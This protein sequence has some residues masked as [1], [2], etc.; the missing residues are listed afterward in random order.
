MVL[1]YDL[2]ITSRIVTRDVSA[3]RDMLIRSRVWPEA[4]AVI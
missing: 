1:C 4:W 2:H 3:L